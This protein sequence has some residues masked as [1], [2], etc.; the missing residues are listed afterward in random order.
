[1]ESMRQK[2]GSILTLVSENERA[3]TR[4]LLEARTG[5][6]EILRVLTPS[7]LLNCVDLRERWVEERPTH[8]H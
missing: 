1:M 5:R 3:H 8:H 2:C 4:E 6:R 7:N